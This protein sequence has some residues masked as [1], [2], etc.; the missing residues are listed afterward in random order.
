MDHQSTNRTEI[1]VVKGDIV[2]LV[3]D[4]TAGF[5]EVT[6]SYGNSGKIPRNCLQRFP[7]T[8]AELELKRDPFFSVS[9][10]VKQ[11]PRTPMPRTII[12]QMSLL[13]SSNNIPVN[14]FNEQVRRQMSFSGNMQIPGSVSAVASRDSGFSYENKDMK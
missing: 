14:N 3:S 12:R 2:K 6:D 9:T 1:S 10:G 4:V 5:T 11:P 13:E 8:A 7:L